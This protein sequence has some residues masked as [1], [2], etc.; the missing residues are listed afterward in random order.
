[1]TPSTS[2]SLS[3]EDSAL[4]NVTGGRNLTD[5]DAAVVHGDRGLAAAVKIDDAGESSWVEEHSELADSHARIDNSWSTGQP[6]PYTKDAVEGD[7][8]METTVRYG[9]D[10]YID[11]EYIN[12]RHAMLGSD[13]DFWADGGLINYDTVDN[14]WK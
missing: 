1:V 10:L 8:D 4:R 6:N 2:S 5:V 13:V 7:W 3:S 14:P 12:L 9:Q 11:K